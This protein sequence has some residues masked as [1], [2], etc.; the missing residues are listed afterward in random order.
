MHKNKNGRRQGGGRVEDDHCMTQRSLAFT[1]YI[2]KPSHFIF[3]TELYG[4][5]GKKL[6][7]S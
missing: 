7:H 2:F 1:T 6:T 5:G 3:K 4:H